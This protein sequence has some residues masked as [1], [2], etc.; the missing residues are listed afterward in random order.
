MANANVI[1]NSSPPTPVRR[2]ITPSTR[3]YA[4]SGPI[5]PA[6]G[7]L[8]MVPASIA[9]AFVISTFGVLKFIR[10]AHEPGCCAQIQP[11]EANIQSI[12]FRNRKPILSLFLLRLASQASRVEPHSTLL[13][14]ANDERPMMSTEAQAYSGSIICPL[15]SKLPSADGTPA[16]GCPPPS[17]IVYLPCATTMSPASVTMLK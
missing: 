14:V 13:R 8:S 16:P 4:G 12:V 5:C 7:T 9:A 6:H 10:L 3:Q 11:A 1:P 2:L 17:E 15:I